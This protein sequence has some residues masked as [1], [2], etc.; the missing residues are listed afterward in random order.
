MKIGIYVFSG[1]GNTARVCGLFQERLI[2]Q[3]CDQK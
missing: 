1:T 2:I 3:C